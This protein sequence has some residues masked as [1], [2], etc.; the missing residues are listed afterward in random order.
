[1][2]ND[3]TFA[4]I[5]PARYDSSRFPGKPLA[6][7]C[8]KPMIQHVWERC[9]KAVGR[10]IVYIATDNSMIS[11][12]AGNFGAKVVLTS[13]NC[14]TGTDRVAEANNQLNYDFIINVQGDEPL[15]NPKD[16]LTV[17]DEYLLNPETVINA[18]SPINDE[19]EF[20][21]L[22]IPKVVASKSGNLLYMSRSPIPTNKANSFVFGF[23][24]VCIYGFSKKH[25]EFFAS[26]HQKSTIE[27]IEDIEILRFVENDI[28]V[29]MVKVGNG[30]IAVDVP[31]DLDKVIEYISND[32]FC[33]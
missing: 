6:D 16:I 29:Q 10:E 8:G 5:I 23:K 7:I 27:Q 15:I 11:N 33:E 1:M 17:I 32:N 28:P 2:S 9:C 30:S 3:K 26:H 31:S 14:L 20:R 24:Q 25:L 19:I 22:T 18:M 21:S 12:V 13:S 4:V